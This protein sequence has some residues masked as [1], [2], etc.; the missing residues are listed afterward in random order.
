[1]LMNIL[2]RATELTS[3]GRLQPPVKHGINEISNVF[4]LFDNLSSLDRCQRQLTKGILT[5]A[6]LLPSLC[7]LCLENMSTCTLV[8]S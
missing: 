2:C 4:I 8:G 6:Y 1:M 5:S 3:M 7:H